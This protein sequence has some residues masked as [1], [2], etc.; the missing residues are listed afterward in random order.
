M[1][2]SLNFAVRFG[3][4]PRRQSYQRRQEDALRILIMG[5]FSGS[6]KAPERP[7]ELSQRSL[8]AVDIDSFEEVLARLAPQLTLSL[9]DPGGEVK[10]LFRQLEDFHPDA[11]YQRLDLFRT[12]RELRQRL[13]HPA[14]FTAAAA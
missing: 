14:T 7:V 11:L 9:G 8:M 4:E 2:G 1:P 13:Q 10:L 6:N 5:D 12:F 3:L